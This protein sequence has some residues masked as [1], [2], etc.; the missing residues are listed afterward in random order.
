MENECPEA[1]VELLRLFTGFEHYPQ[2]FSSSP[3]APTHIRSEMILIKWMAESNLIEAEIKESKEGRLH[4]TPATFTGSAR[5][6]SIK[7]KGFDVLA[8]FIAS[9]KSDIEKVSDLELQ[10]LLDSPHPKNLWF[11]MAREEMDMRIS[12]AQKESDYKEEKADKRE[13]SR[14]RQ[15]LILE[16]AGILIA[17]GAASW[18]G[19]LAYQ[20]QQLKIQV[21]QLSERLNALEKRALDEKQLG[22][23]APPQSTSTPPIAALPNSDEAKPSALMQPSQTRQPT[24]NPEETPK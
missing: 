3:Y 21:L 11:Q 1:A 15:S 2:M 14:H 8:P 18:T 16:C 7:R 24:P 10:R 6:V 5:V 23:P 12:K 13:D 9:A 4:G 20:D 19:Y 17:L 22:T